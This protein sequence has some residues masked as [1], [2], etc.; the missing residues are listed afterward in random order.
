MVPWYFGALKMRPVLYIFVIESVFMHLSFS[1]AE[2][3]CNVAIPSI[4]YETINK[5]LVKYLRGHLVEERKYIEAGL[6]D[7]GDGVA[8]N[9]VEATLR[10]LQQ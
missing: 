7:D 2:T 1:A 5:R 3:A 9:A 10:R 4:N 6:V 8:D